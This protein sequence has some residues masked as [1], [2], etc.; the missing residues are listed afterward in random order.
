[1]N[2][3]KFKKS[4]YAKAGKSKRV[5]PEEK[6]ERIT[7]R[8]NQR[9]LEWVRQTSIKEKTNMSLLIRE[10]LECYKEYYL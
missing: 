7:I 5:N 6:T 8:I 1:M 3:Y 4:D 10:A 2:R 9:L